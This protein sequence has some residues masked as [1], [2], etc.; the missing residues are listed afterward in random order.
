[1]TDDRPAIVGLSM[2]GLC[3]MRVNLRGDHEAM[4]SE[5]GMQRCHAG[6]RNLEHVLGGILDRSIRP[7]N[8]NALTL[9]PTEPQHHALAPAPARIAQFCKRGFDER[10]W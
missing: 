8:G 10:R 5:L 3:G 6:G 7:V 9:A 4:F 2:K 1:M